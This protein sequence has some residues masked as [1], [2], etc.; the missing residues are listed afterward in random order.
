MAQSSHYQSN[1]RD[2]FFNL[3]EVFQ[4]QNESLGQGPFSEIDRSVAEELLRNAQVL[5]EGPYAEGFASADHEGLSIDNQGNVS[6]PSGIRQSLEAYYEGEWQRLTAPIELGGY[7][8]PPS[9]YWA[10]FELFVGAN[11]SATFY[12]L[13]EVNAQ[14]IDRLGTPRQR[15]LFSQ[16]IIERKWGGTMM[17]TEPDAGS[18]VGSGLAKAKHIEG[19]AWH[20]EGTKRYI[21]NGDYDTTENIIHLVLARPQGAA[22][23]TPGLSMFIVPKFLVNED[24][25]LG[26]RNG[27][28]ATQL[29][30]KMGLT[31]SATCEMT[32]GERAPCIGYLVGDEHRGMRQMF[33]VIEHARMAVGFKSFSTL[34]TAYLQALR[35]TKERIQGPDLAQ[36]TNRSAPRVPIIRHPDVRRML[37]TQKAFTEG[38]RALGL[39]AASI[40]DRVR[41]AG[42]HG[43][44]EAK[45]LDRLNDLLLPLIKGYF[46]EKVYTLLGN[47]SLQCFGGAG[48]LKDYPIE[49]YVRDQKIDT[50]YEGTTHIQALD[51]LFRKVAKDG[52]ATLQGLFKQ[53]EETAKSDVGG[54]HC[55][56]AKTRLSRALA[57]VQGIFLAAMQKMGDSIY[58][59][60]IQGNRIL[61]SLAELTIGWLLIRQAEVAAVAIEQ[62]SGKERSFYEGKLAIAHFFSGEV[63]P[64]LTLARKQV[65]ASSL[66]VMSLSDSA[67]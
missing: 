24:G 30:K 41:L 38:M 52:G 44:P 4:V 22:E 37:L 49:Q 32:L 5:A 51:L 29:E 6:L 56:V 40:Q 48:Y 53:I 10:A 31:A 26:E 13:G 58:H 43:H 3:F 1:L 25:T 28:Y 8:A 42:G 33:Q 18:D 23:G 34:S 50:L 20:L 54:E 65:E 60:G 35:Y 55:A 19:D 45:R 63:F 61:F 59:M 9:I 11:A 16:R 27:V 46:S 62:A 2:I 17:L 7:G 14:V 36:A 39:Y 12:L 57:D 67:F 21:T 66:E 15:E 64:G 47:S